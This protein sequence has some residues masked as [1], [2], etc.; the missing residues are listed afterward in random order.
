MPF[1][2]LAALPAPDVAASPL[3]TAAFILVALVLVALN[4]FFVLAEFALVKVRAQRLQVLA[5]EGSRAAARTIEILRRLDVYLASSQVGITMASLGLGWIG[6]PAFVGVFRLLADL[7]GWWTPGVS[8]TLSAVCAFVLITALHIILGEQAPKYLAI[9][10]AEAMALF[11]ARP[12]HWFTVA[13]YAPIQALNLL[14]NGVLRLLRIQ[15]AST[16]ELAHSEEELRTIFGASHEQG[17]FTLSRLLM[18]ENILDLG[19]LKVRDI[20]IPWGKIVCLDAGAPW[21]QNLKRIQECR[22]SRYPILRNQAVI[23]MVHIKDLVLTASPFDLAKSLRAPVT[24]RPDLPCEELLRVFQ[25]RQQHMTIVEETPG[26]PIGFVS[27]EQLL[28]ELVG[29]IR[30]EYEQAREIS[31]LS[32]VPPEAIALDIEAKTKEDAIRALVNALAAL[33]P[34]IQTAPLVA[35]ILKREAI[36]STGIGDGI[37][38][39]HERVSGL[40]RPMAAIGRLAEGIDF[41]SVDKQPVRLVFL[42]LT[43][44]GDEGTHLR[45]IEKIA[46]FLSSEYLRGRLLS[47]KAPGEVVEILRVADKSVLS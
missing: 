9:R 37:G 16:L 34:A 27:L 41:A 19:K 1:P 26:R 20:M 45:I 13:F 42:I 46:T 35:S 23:G 3:E 14:A 2:F 18:L 44:M 5:R 17:A 39:P 40:P 24:V 22:Y 11:C 47:A 12:L 38:I 28:E 25:N 6:E 15:P 31:L 8:H 10:R 43:A 21:E 4:A 29:P 32:L 36:A 7:P 33:Q 30:D